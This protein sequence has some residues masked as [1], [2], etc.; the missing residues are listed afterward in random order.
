MK[1]ARG[2]LDHLLAP[3]RRYCAMMRKRRKQCPALKAVS[4]YTEL[5]MQQQGRERLGNLRPKLPNP[6]RYFDKSVIIPPRPPL[7]SEVM[8]ETDCVQKKCMAGGHS[9][10]SLASLTAA[11]MRATVTDWLTD[12][13]R[14]IYCIVKQGTDRFIIDAA[15]RS[16]NIWKETVFNGT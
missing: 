7:F 11:R 12:Y 3:P 16:S 1:E 15:F 4:R 9:S 10:G 14:T 13:C 8:S 5:R 2:S 6:L